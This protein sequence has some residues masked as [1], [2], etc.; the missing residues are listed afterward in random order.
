MS[1]S[2]TWYG[3]AT[4]GL[5]L[6]GTRVIVDPFLKGNSPVART[7]AAE[8][9]VDYVWLTHG[10]GDHVADALS[11]AQRC[12]ATLI[13]NFEITAWYEGQGHSK[14]HPQHLGGGFKHPFGYLKMTPA[15]HG[16]MLP[17]GSNGGMPGGFLLKGDKNIYISG[18]T[19]LFSDMSLIGAH[20]LDVA[21]VCIGDNFTMGP[22]D[23]ILAIQYLQ[24]KVV[25]PCHYN[26][27]GYIMVDVDAW[28]R[29]VEQETDARPEVMQIDATYVVE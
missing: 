23:S 14:T 3:H 20:G 19:A 2:I 9:D 28:A 21:I 4:F 5:D 15:L 12:Q 18:D 11:I 25:I 16:S 29:R 6:N 1:Y 24:P 8:I 7:A 10:H 22:D 13:S 26:T 17:D 27:F